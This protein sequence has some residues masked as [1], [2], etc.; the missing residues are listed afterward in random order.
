V[1]RGLSPP[2]EC[3]LPGA[4]AQK[5]IELDQRLW[6]GHIVA[7]ALHCCRFSWDAAEKAFEAA[8]KIDPRETSVSFFYIAYLEALGKHREADTCL[9]SRIALRGSTRFA[10]PIQAL[11][12]YLRGEGFGKGYGVLLERSAS[13]P[14][15]ESDDRYQSGE[16]ILSFDFWVVSI[17]AACV[18]SRQGA[19]QI[20]WRYAEQGV[21][22]SK[23]GAFAGVIVLTYA[24]HGKQHRK[25]ARTAQTFLK[26]LEGQR[27]VRAFSLLDESGDQEAASAFSLALAY[28]GVGETEQ[29][30]EKLREA[31]D[32]GFPLVIFLHYWPV[33][34]P[35]REHDE[36]KK[37]IERMNLPR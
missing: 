30:I 28:V 13:G 24:A 7:G 35:L 37:L 1:C 6:L 12:D 19:T 34:D 2:S 31:C 21:R 16:I 23:V 33:F 11:F 9:M 32:E 27:R 17:L 14:S 5:A 3:A 26:Q 29:A 20:A 18:C 10:W 8:M 15:I 25:F 36:F 4:P 22:D